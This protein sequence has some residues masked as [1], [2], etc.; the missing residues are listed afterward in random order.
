MSGPFDLGR[1]V[2]D[3]AIGAADLDAAVAAGVISA[4]AGRALRDF[5]AGRHTGPSATVD[6]EDIRFVTSFN[7]FFV[8]LGI[9]LLTGSVIVLVS[10]LQPLLTAPAV[11]ALAWGLAE[12]FTARRRMAFP[13][14]VLV[15]VF[16]AACAMSVVMVVGDSSR[17]VAFLGG[18]GALV[19]AF[20]HWRR[21]GVPIAMAAMTAGAVGM[22]IGLVVAIAPKLVEDHFGIV[23]LTAGLAVFA[24]AM[25]WDSS[26]RERRTRRTDTAFWLHILAAPLIVH[27][28]AS[29]LGA[30]LGHGTIEA[31]GFVLA[32]FALLAVVALV[33]DRRALLVSALAYFGGSILM[34]LEKSGWVGSSGA[35]TTIGVVGAVVLILSIAWAPMRAYV[36]RFVPSR[37][38]AL[39]PAPR[40]LEGS[41][42]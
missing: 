23:L 39:V 24:F 34:L 6:E 36:L 2:E 13:S 31:P 7:D 42:T 27:P 15:G 40:R 32:M 5:A 22:T 3:G 21:F 12:I 19:A 18:G 38:R 29:M 28:L 37:I 20:V 30:G 25:R 16:V 41:A 14:I 8:T 17:F 26:D 10:M 4:E 35:A 9:A 33:V 11:A 1:P